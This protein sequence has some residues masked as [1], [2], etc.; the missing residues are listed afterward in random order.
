MLPASQQQAP[1]TRLS[2][3]GGGV[4]GN[5]ICRVCVRKKCAECGLR[6]RL[7]HETFSD[8]AVAG[9]VP[10]VPPDLA[11]R[12]RIPPEV[13]LDRSEAEVDPLYAEGGPTGPDSLQ[14]QTRGAISPKQQLLLWSK[15]DDFRRS[16]AAKLREVG[17]LD[18]ADD[19]DGCHSYFTFAR[20]KGCHTVRKFP[21]RCD[22]FYCPSC[23]PGLAKARAGSVEWWTKGISQPKH[24]VLTIKNTADLTRGHIKE[25]KKW[26]SALRRRKFAR[27][28]VGG[29]YSVEVTNEGKGWHLHLHILVDARW[30]DAGELAI[31]WGKVTNQA[32]HIVKVKDVREGSYLAE[33]TKYAVKGSQL[34]KWTGEQ[35]R[36]FIQAFQ[37]VRCFGV[38]GSLFGKRTQW[39]EWIE[40]AREHGL[41]CDCGCKEWDYFSEQE[42][43]AEEI[44]HD[45][46]ALSRP[47]PKLPDR[48]LG[49]S[50]PVEPFRL[51]HPN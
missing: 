28:W 27:N 36:T 34:A 14:V 20:C 30:I 33:V 31:Q 48:Q 44:R 26:F 13:N 21:N 12:V 39:A 11:F 25:L 51:I 49:W 2:G 40:A 16:I 23:Q 18:L 37:G 9:S 46:A 6:E 22:R 32:G 29:F 4:A 7:K 1:I 19:L 24:V 15:Q 5:G 41:Q 3:E 17:E 38:F 43:A 35:I 42:W 45:L 8:V 50:F 47:P 10:V